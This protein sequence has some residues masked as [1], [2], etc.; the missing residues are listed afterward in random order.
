MQDR[1]DIMS[2]VCIVARFQANPKESHVTTVKIIFRYLKGTIDF[3]LWYPKNDD[4]TLSSF[5]DVDWVGD[6]NDMKSTSGG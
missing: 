6:V 5:I 2:V 1:L 3:G 4:L